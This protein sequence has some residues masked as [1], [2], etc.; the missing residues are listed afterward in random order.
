MKPNPKLDAIVRRP[1]K[2]L[3]QFNAQNP[4]FWRDHDRR[5]AEYAEGHKWPGWCYLPLHVTTRSMWRIRADRGISLHAGEAVGVGALASWRLTKGIYLFDETV[6]EELWHTDITGNLPVELL[7][8]LPEWGV[9]VPFLRPLEIGFGLRSHGFFAYLDFDSHEDCWLHLNLDSEDSE[10]EAAMNRI[11]LRLIGNLAECC[12]PFRAMVDKQFTPA[13]EGPE[14]LA[15]LEEWKREIEPDLIRPMV[16]ILLWL[17]SAEPEI[18]PDPLR[19]LRT[20]K[21]RKGVRCFGPDEPRFYEVAYRIGAAL[22]LSRAARPADGDGSHS[23]PHPHIRRAH[24]HS[25]W[26][27]P[28]ASITKEQPADRKLVLKWIAPIA[29]CAGLPGDTIIPTV[30]PVREAFN[31]ALASR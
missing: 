23:S 4:G 25:Y 29:V 9:Y 26:T 12:A 5:R 30:H 18:N 1:V 13:F 28:K 31:A 14:Q 2:H 22:R 27:G 3:A 11:S 24:W 8:R 15:V 10:N 6:F 19:G 21:T 16:S 7:Q 20:K 17:C